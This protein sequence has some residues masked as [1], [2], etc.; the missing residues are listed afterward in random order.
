MKRARR[1][2]SKRGLDCVARRMERRLLRRARCW[3]SESGEWQPWKAGNGC[4]VGWREGVR[5][6]AARRLVEAGKAYAVVSKCD[7][8]GVSKRGWKE[9]FV[10][11]SWKECLRYLGPRMPCPRPAGLEP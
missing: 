2:T 6:R 5:V 11:E 1:K 10:T 8:L 7:F 3:R 9:I 4:H